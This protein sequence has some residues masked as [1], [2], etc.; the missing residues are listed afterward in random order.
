MD[1]TSVESS[2]VNKM[3]CSFRKTHEKDNSEL[4]STNKKRRTW[5]NVFALVVTWLDTIRDCPNNKVK[6]ECKQI[7]EMRPRAR[8]LVS[9]KTIEG[10]QT[11]HFNIIRLTLKA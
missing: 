8:E 10:N 6:D 4:R 7:S 3:S 11:D 5:K 1:F 9:R 2:I